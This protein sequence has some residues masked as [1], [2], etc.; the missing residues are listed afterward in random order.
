MLLGYPG[1]TARHKTASF[2]EFEQNVRL[3]FV[4]DYYGQQIETMQT[5]GA[6]DRAV[7]LKLLSRISG[8]A[9]VEKRSRGQHR[10]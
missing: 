10:G 4:V 7:A 2:L 6:K 8:L 9:N 1:R 5:A 3:P